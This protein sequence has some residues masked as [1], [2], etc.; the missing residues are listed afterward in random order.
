[1]T[2][3]ETF[4]YQGR[5]LS[6]FAH[7]KRWK[8][9]WASRIGKWVSGDVLEV[10]AGI[11]SN[12]P[13][14]QNETV[15]S[16]HCLEP[17]P[18]LAAQLRAAAAAVPVCSTITGTIRGIRGMRFNSILYIDVLEH[19]ARDREELGLAARLLAPG[20]HLVVLSP[21]H[22]FL[23]SEFDTEI[24]HYRRYS[25]ASLRACSPRDCRPEA[26]FHLDSA[27]ILLSLANRLA[28]RQSTP[29]LKQIRTWDKYAVPLS[30]VLDPLLAHRVGKT[31]VAVW[32][33]V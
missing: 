12:T 27:G 23:F 9:Y 32:T 33:H 28:L 19:I 16:W 29:S 14:L 25:R 20:G 21:A 5:E 1:M 24:G 3:S 13:A 7:A 30:R 4:H 18:E 8:A 31:I 26:L 11:G 17:D 10:G 22:Q 2:A 15:R 6:V